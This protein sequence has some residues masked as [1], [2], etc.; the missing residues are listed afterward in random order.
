MSKGVSPCSLE[1][2]ATTSAPGRVS[3]CPVNASRLC[4]TAKWRTVSLGVVRSSEGGEGGEGR[5]GEGREGG[6]GGREGREG[7]EGGRGGREEGEGGR[8][9][10]KGREE[11]GESI[12]EY[13]KRVP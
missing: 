4:L 9:G 8:G 2:L 1:S 5:G 12:A 7:R 6:R 11:G 3:R 10:R 13:K